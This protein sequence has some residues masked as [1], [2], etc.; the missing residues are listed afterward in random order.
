[1]MYSKFSTYS[2]F[3]TVGLSLAI[4]SGRLAAECVQGDCH[5]GR[6]RDEQTLNGQVVEVYEGQWKDGFREGSGTVSAYTIGGVMYRR[7]SGSFH[8]GF[9]HGYGKEVFFESNEQAE[10]SYEGSFEYGHRSGRGVHV[11]YNARG[12]VALR[13]EGIWQD[14]DLTGVVERFR[15]DGSIA[16][17]FT[18]ECQYVQR[19]EGQVTRFDRRGNEVSV[20][21]GIFTDYFVNIPQDNIRR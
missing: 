2:I 12:G 9:Y 17:R 15:L 6:G 16:S 18:G 4:L 5:N 3:L 8:R 20:E 21:N 1:M 14:N 7:Y 10:S 13:A 11:V 19:C